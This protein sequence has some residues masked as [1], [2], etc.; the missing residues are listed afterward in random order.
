MSLLCSLRSPPGNAGT[1][2]AFKVW[3]QKLRKAPLRPIKAFTK[4]LKRRQMEAESPITRNLCTDV[5]QL[6]QSQGLAS[7][8]PARKGFYSLSKLGTICLSLFLAEGKSEPCI[9]V[10]YRLIAQYWFP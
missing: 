3:L 1:C 9:S 10:I 6:E 4:R 2:S 7:A 5:K 8:V